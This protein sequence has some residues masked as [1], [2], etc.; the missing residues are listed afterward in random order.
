MKTGDSWSAGF[1]LSW[2]SLKAGLQLALAAG[3]LLRGTNA[4][5]DEKADAVRDLIPWLLD[6]KESLKGIRFADVIAATSGK[7]ILPFGPADADDQRVLRQIGSAMDEV[8]RQMNAPESPVRSARR[9]NEMSSHFETALRVA[10]NAQPGLACDFPKTADGKVQRSGY[11]DLRI[12][13][14]AT[15]RIVYLDPKLYA[16]GSRA[17]SFRTFYF[18]PKRETNKVTD[19]ARHLIVGIE[20]GQDAEGATQFLRWELIDLAEFRVKLKAE[21]EGS[22]ADLYRPEAI[23][24]RSAPAAKQE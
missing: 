18:E 22:N 14:A 16:K 17:S 21:F 9:V 2:D 11:P 6:E 3:S 15:K 20:H 4:R 1:S 10:L 19:D 24:G 12:V 23:V 8:L 13:D 7:K 5:A